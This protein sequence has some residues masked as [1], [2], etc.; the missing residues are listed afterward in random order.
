MF[1]TNI[2]LEV[3]F[4]VQGSTSSYLMKIYGQLLCQWI[5]SAKFKNGFVC[6]VAYR[7]TMICKYLLIDLFLKLLS[8]NTKWWLK[9]GR[10]YTLSNRVSLLSVSLDDFVLW[11]LFFVHVQVT[12]FLFKHLSNSYLSQCNAFVRTVS[13][14]YAA[15]AMSYYFPLE[16][17]LQ[18]KD[19]Q[20]I[21][22]TGTI[23]F[24]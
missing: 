8:P 3:K 6:S 2:C 21:A 16:S 17:V 5:L 12:D 23:G 18:F 24:V 10:N 19:S 7:L 13:T 4:W 11:A 9:S 15:W 22:Y 14:D 20:W 1:T